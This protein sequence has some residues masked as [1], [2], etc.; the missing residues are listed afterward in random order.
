MLL[1]NEMIANLDYV[2]MLFNERMEFS[3]SEKNLKVNAYHDYNTERG[4]DMKE[5][6]TIRKRGQVTLPKSF[7]E[8]FNLGEGDILELEVNK[9]GEITVTP[10]V[11]VP[12]SQK[13]FWTEEW[14]EGEEEAD[15]DIRTGRVK[16]FN[17]VEDL[18]DDLESDN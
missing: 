16:S 8:K 5:R 6:L 9:K 1:L 14:Q 4:I 12:S 15:R 2:I 10:M 17:N 13:W 18:I 11:N 7:L 3:K